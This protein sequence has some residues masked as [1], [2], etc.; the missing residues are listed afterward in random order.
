MTTPSNIADI[1]RDYARARARRSRSDPDPISSSTA[2]SPRRGGAVAGAERDDAGHGHARRGSVG[3]HRAAR[4]C[5]ERGFVFFTDYRSRKGGELEANPRAALVFYW[6]ELERQV[7]INGAVTGSRGGIGALLPEPSPR[8]PARR[9]GVA[10]EPGDP[11]AG[12]LEADLKEVEAAVRRGRRPAAAVL[13]RIS[14]GAGAIEFWQGR[15]NRLHDRIRYV[16]EGGG[17]E[18][19]VE[20]LSP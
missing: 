16:R 5:D 1:R 13:G 19:K 14:R 9:L 17:K 15:E 20:R 11:G 12:G 2:G 3:A 4:G 7:R 18:W 8:Q 6:G 10:P